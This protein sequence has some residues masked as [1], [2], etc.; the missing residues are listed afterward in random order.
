MVNILL[1]VMSNVKQAVK[2]HTAKHSYTSPVLYWNFQDVTNLAK[3]HSVTEW[4]S[5]D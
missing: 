4:K 3:Q 5:W 1:N 2:S